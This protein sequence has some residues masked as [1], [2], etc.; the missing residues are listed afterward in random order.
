MYDSPAKA[1]SSQRYA[2][3]KAWSAKGYHF[4]KVPF[5]EMFEYKLISSMDRAAPV[6]ADMAKS[7]RTTFRA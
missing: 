4:A 7:K 1:I 6:F 3:A 2:K 5:E